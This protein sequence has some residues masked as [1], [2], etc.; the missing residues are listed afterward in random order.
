[1]RGGYA[2]IPGSPDVV[3]GFAAGLRAEAQRVASAQERLL[4]L[5]HGS[6]WDSPAGRAFAAEVVALPPVLDAVAQRY[7]GAAAALREFACAFR[8]AQQECN[9]AITLRERGLLRRDRYLEAL[10]RAETS[11]LPQERARVP[12]LQR[13]MVEAAGEVLDNERRWCAARKRFDEADRRC[14]RLLGG[15]AHD[16]LTDSLQ[17]DTVKGAARLSDSVSANAACAALVPT[18]RPVAV[19]VGATATASG[20]LLDGVVKVAYDEGQWS[21]LAEEA[22]LDTV[23]FATGA[24]R[25]GALARG[26]SGKTQG[27]V[28]FSSAGDR[29]RHGLASEARDGVP[30]RVRPA[31]KATTPPNPPPGA[32]PG[33]PPGA[34]RPLPLRQRVRAAARERAMRPVRAARADWASATR[35]GAD[36][37]TML[38]TAWGLKGGT[39]AYTRGKQ[40][41]QAWEKAQERSRARVARARP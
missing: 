8:E 1:M 13:L 5:R 25:A 39:T 17:Y 18:W 4:A 19:A 12:E 16:S 9:L 40:V 11:E 15:L 35:S 20:F 6:R 30:W 10:G 14:S 33:T 34:Y 32:P 38:L 37:R 2:P 28:G 23:G 29:L 41:N 22:A 36:A 26:L 3:E 7:A 21:T 31:P 24:L 27:P